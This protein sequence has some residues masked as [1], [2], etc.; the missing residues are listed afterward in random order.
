VFPTNLLRSFIR[1]HIIF[2]VAVGGRNRKVAEAYAKN[3]GKRFVFVLFSFSLVYN[4]FMSE[5]RKKLISFTCFSVFSTDLLMSLKLRCY[6]ARSCRY[7]H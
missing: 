4:S 7:I 2:V 5:K 6:K 3:G 1:N